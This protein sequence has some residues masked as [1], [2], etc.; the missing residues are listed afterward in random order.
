MI[1]HDS[2]TYSPQMIITLTVNNG[3]EC[4][5]TVTTS[6]LSM[7]LPMNSDFPKELIVSWKTETISREGRSFVCEVS[8]EKVSFSSHHSIAEG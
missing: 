8:Q 4:I 1:L 6:V 5:E 3:Q 7:F 2:K